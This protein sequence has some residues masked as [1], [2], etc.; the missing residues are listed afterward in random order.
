LSRSCNGRPQP[1]STDCS[2]TASSTRAV[3]VG[4]LIQRLDSL[5]EGL[6]EPAAAANSTASWIRREEKMPC[7]LTHD[8]LHWVAELCCIVGRLL[9]QL[10][11]QIDS[12]GG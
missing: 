4:H 5:G 6:A 8:F 12:L 1:A 11:H 3:D 7:V 9:N 2:H 10:G